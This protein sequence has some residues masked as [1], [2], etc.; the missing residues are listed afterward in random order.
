MRSMLTTFEHI[1]RG[2]CKV[3]SKL[4]KFEH[5]WGEGRSI[6]QGGGS[7]TGTPPFVDRQADMIEN[8]TFDTP[9]ADGNNT[10]CPTP[11]IDLF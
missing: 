9:L 3:R 10:L 7:G 5:V 6:A 1:H 2:P 8:I 4:K 11:F